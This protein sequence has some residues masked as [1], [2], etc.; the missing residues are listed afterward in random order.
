MIAGYTP[1]LPT[2]SWNE[3]AQFT[4]ESVRDMAVDSP[5]NAR[6]YL[7]NVARL[8]LWARRT[9]GLDLVREEI[10]DPSTISR[11]LES[12]RGTLSPAT[13]Q[14]IT[15]LL[16]RMS[17]ALNDT[18]PES[19]RYRR[20]VKRKAGLYVPSEFATMSSW[21]ATQHTPDQRRDA[22]AIVGFGLGAG[23]RT[24]ELSAA[25]VEDVKVE[26]AGVTITV[27]GAHPRTVPVHA[28]WEDEA[29]AA[30]L[31]ARVGEYL[32]LPGAVRNSHTL[33][34]SQFSR[35]RG[36]D[37]PTMERLRAT[38]VVR[39]MELL[40]VRAA[41]HFAGLASLGAFTPY[42]VHTADIEFDRATAKLR[43]SG[44]RW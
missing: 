38:W 42:I 27:R 43:G 31:G 41:A 5:G 11:Y 25:R 8:S 22:N 6:A 19:F 12:V 32:L 13:H 39:T 1:L 2:G 37:V 23:L 21:A 26:S 7:T 15:A 17:G 33:N 10:F 14:R 3:V 4:R 18:A 20:R 34:L 28:L 40:P 35:R 24:N 44:D 29:T 16:I 9:A 36:E 30:V